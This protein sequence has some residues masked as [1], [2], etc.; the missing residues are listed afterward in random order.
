MIP[1]KEIFAAA[2][3]AGIRSENIERDY[4]LSWLLKSIVE[5]GDFIGRYAFK[6]GRLSANS[7]SPITVIHK[8]WISQ[9]RRR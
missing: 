5:T 4:V 9:S 6:G 2:R 1:R 8:T 3:V 7:I